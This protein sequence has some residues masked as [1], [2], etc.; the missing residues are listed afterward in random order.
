MGL[1][2]EGERRE[3]VAEEEEVQ[4]MEEGCGVRAANN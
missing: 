4:K 1:R 2:A 3:G